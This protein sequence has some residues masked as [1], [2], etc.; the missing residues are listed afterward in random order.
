MV[1]HVTAL[2]LPQYENTSINGLGISL[3]ND[4]GLHRPRPEGL[5]NI[6]ALVTNVTVDIRSS[7]KLAETRFP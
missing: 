7:W 2:L 6:I 5:V 4:L 1:S 3:D